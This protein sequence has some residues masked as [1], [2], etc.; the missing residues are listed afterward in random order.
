MSNE[1]PL[2]I[3][4]RFFYIIQLA[5]VHYYDKMLKIN[6]KI[7]CRKFKRVCKMS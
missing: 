5:L 1:M 4:V 3:C 7:V 2:L 6:V